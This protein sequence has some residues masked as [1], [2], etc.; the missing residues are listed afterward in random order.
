MIANVTPLWARLEDNVA[1]P[2]AAVHLAER[3]RAHD[4]PVREHPARPAAALAFGSDWSV[5]TPDP[6]HQLATAVARRDPEADTDEPLLPDERS[7]WAA[8]IAAQTI[9][10]AHASFL[11]EHDRHR[12][13]R[14]SWPT[15]W[16]STAT[17]SGCRRPATSR[18][19]CG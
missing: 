6:L 14:A 12:S 3:P 11:D 7:T 5:S 8:A 17:C 9:G 16:C 15:W 13:S 4:L 10:A 19:G 18:P 2:H 1:R